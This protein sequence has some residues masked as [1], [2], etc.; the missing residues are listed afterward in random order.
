MKNEE[1]P[2][3]PGLRVR[4]PMNAPPAHRPP[5]VRDEENCRP[6]Q[7]FILYSSL[8][9]LHSYIR[10][11]LSARSL[12]LIVR[13]RTLLFLVLALFAPAAAR[14][15]GGAR[16]PEFVHRLLGGSPTRSYIDCDGQWQYSGDGESWSTLTVPCA[17]DY[18]GP[19]ILKKSFLLSPLQRKHFTWKFVALGV[20]YQCDILVNDQFVTHSVGGYTTCAVI[21]PEYALKDGENVITITGSNILGPR[22][23][24]PTTL[25]TFSVRN[26]GGI[27]RHAALIGLPAVS[28]SDIDVS[29]Q[30]AGSTAEA[31]VTVQIAAGRL[32]GAVVPD[33]TLRASP[34][35]HIPVTVRTEIADK[36]TGQVVATATAVATIEDFRAKT[37]AFTIPIPSPRLWSCSSPVLYTARCVLQH[38][39][40]PGDEY[41]STFGIR[42]FA[43]AGDGFTLNGVPIELRGAV[44]M[45]DRRIE[46][47][48]LD[49]QP[50]EQDVQLLK[51]LGANAVRTLYPASPLFLALCDEYG[52]LVFEQIPTVRAP[53]S[54]VADPSYISVSKNYLQ[55]MILRDRNHPSVVAWGM[56]SWVD[57]ARSGDYIAQLAALAGTLDERPVFATAPLLHPPHAKGWWFAETFGDEIPDL[58]AAMRSWRAAQPDVPLVLAGY[59]RVV[60]PDTHNGYTDPRSVEAQSRYL[61]TTHTALQQE[62]AGGGFVMAFADWRSD[63]PSILTVES[64]PY[65]NF[66]GLVSYGREERRQSYEVVKAMFT[67]DKIPTLVVGEDPA[68][69]PVTY[70]VVGLVFLLLLVYLAN[71]S[72]RFRENFSRAV[73]RPFNFFADVRDQRILST[74]QTTILGVIT[75]GTFAIFLSS[76]CYYLRMS[77]SF[78]MLLNVLLPWNPLKFRMAQLVWSPTACSIAFTLVF[79]AALIVFT[80]VVRFC[81]VFVRPRIF[82]GDAYAIVM[83]AAL[84]TVALIPIAMILYRVMMFG[85]YVTTA[86][87]L[88]VAV[89]AW[90]TFRVLRGVAVVFDIP[91]RRVYTAAIIIVLGVG[92]AAVYALDSRFGS[93]AQFQAVLRQILA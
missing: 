7:I 40:T 93:I 92:A 45:E 88:G 11:M 18:Q 89:I 87:A 15:Q 57:A 4:G 34:Q 55:A 47:S 90:V 91:F 61:L 28:I 70:I 67:G 39:S 36:T 76:I 52:L 23:T 26:Y 85:P 42:S 44:Y 30:A 81:A 51:T 37:V 17:L 80:A 27:Y 72:R 58:A 56:G 9:N 38:D 50:L 32:S 75:A 74:V 10:R 63:R 41:T 83:W 53:S 6:I 84:P 65:T 20:N 71:N 24:S 46:G 82:F 16:G 64:D 31:H 35:A 77:V 59:G 48:A 21:I 66:A 60:R 54:V 13:R 25:T 78:D 12:R 3:A 49:V 33:S 62:H 43:A 22:E 73:F 8:F 29:A 14:A 5:A 68:T 2:G 69:A 1:G 86:V 19:F 79:F